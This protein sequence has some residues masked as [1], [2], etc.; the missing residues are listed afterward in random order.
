MHQPFYRQSTDGR[1]GL[2]WVRL[3]A[4]KDYLHI[5][6]VITDYPT[7]RQ[8]INVVPSLGQQILEYAAGTALDRVLELSLKL[9]QSDARL[10][11][12]ERREILESFFS[13]NWDHFV[14][15]VPRFSQLA[16]M[17]EA[18][19]GDPTLFSTQYFVDLAVWYNL[20]WIDPK[21]RSRDP[22]LRA[23]TEKGAGFDRSDLSTVLEKHREICG[24][25]IPAYR[26]LAQR[27]QIEITTSPYFHP[28][29]PL[30]IDSYSARE[31]SPGLPLP[32]LRF[33]YPADAARQIADAIAFHERTFGE[34]PKGLWPP[35][36]AISLAAVRLVGSFP[37]I[38]W[39]ASDEHV[40][41]RSLGRTIDRDE[42][43][44]ARQPDTLYR[45]YVADD[46]PAIFFRDQALSDRVGFA[47]QH[48]NSV[49]AANDL[50]ERLLHVQR[51]LET[52][53]PRKVP[54]VVSIVLDGENCWETYP[55]NGDDFL[56]A[57][58][59][60]LAREPSL[61]TITPSQYLASEPGLRERLERLPALPAASWISSNLETW[62]GEP[63]QNRA[64][65]YLTATRRHFD[66]WEMQHGHEHEAARARARHA[67]YSAEGSDWFWWYYSHNRVS[68][69]DAFDRHFREELATVFRETSQPTPEWLDHPVHGHA[70]ART[71]EMLGPISP[72]PLTAPPE[73][74]PE[75]AEAAYVDLEQSTGSMQVGSRPLRRTYCGY[76]ASN[77]YVRVEVGPEVS[78]ES[79][80]VFIA[81]RDR[82]RTWRLRVR[83]SP[84]D[85]VELIARHELGEWTSVHAEVR[86]AAGLRAVELAVNW[87]ELGLRRG[88]SVEVTAAILGREDLNVLPS[89]D[90]VIRLALGELLVDEPSPALAEGVPHA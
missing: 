85:C 10:S 47:Y 62:I 11:D 64:W 8:T 36:G 29:L 69:I 75:W 28:I 82:S 40:L 5:A 46:G 2:P 77:L 21:E 71:R 45:P 18:A 32:H 17:R 14:L 52:V 53:G 50:V 6:H 31:S 44:H 7:V 55:N 19:H 30:L 12:D 3:H 39:V 80:G 15:P 49:D 22:V 23:L 9:A 58:F 76:D 67:L 41:A 86:V 79:V 1:Y 90:S 78:P 37:G 57:L 48:W 61:T 87:S 34:P 72:L 56:R 16:R 89:G 24:A 59:A 60:R 54:P 26:A 68:S 65:E 73:A 13:I 33:H 83:R 84:D 27:N 51:A 42:Y 70:A 88:S 66:A 35:E 38:G 74:G 81:E 43:G 4:V 63:D 20:A 25:V